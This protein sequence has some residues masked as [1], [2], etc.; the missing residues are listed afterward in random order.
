MTFDNLRCDCA[1]STF[2][3]TIEI[4]ACQSS[5]KKAFVSV[6]ERK[7]GDGSRVQTISLKIGLPFEQLLSE[8]NRREA[9]LRKCICLSK[10]K[11]GLRSSN[12]Q[13]CE[14]KERLALTWHRCTHRS[15]RPCCANVARRV[16]WIFLPVTTDHWKTRAAKEKRSV[17]TWIVP[18]R[19]F[20]TSR[21]LHGCT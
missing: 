6:D 14:T 19:G 3:Q 16:N 13:R 18:V 17:F 21:L 2:R 12:V 10:Y 1:H 11:D 7:E 20:S 5:Q 8:L 15:S 4:N 9:S